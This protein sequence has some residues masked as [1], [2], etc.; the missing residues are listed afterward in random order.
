[1]TAPESA[2]RVTV[3]NDANE[4]SIMPRTTLRS[5]HLLS[6]GDLDSD[7]INLI[8]DTAEAMK[9]ILSLIHI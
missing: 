3:I 8:L 9:E 7:E 2:N 4:T 6:S 5:R 1:M